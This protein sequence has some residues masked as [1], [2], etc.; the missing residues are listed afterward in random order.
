MKEGFVIPKN[1]E[2]SDEDIKLINKFTKRDL[3]KN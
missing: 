2:T 1:E 3:N